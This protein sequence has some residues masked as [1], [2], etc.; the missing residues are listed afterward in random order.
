MGDSWFSPFII[1]LNFFFKVVILFFILS[2]IF[3]KL[4]DNNYISANHVLAIA[5]NISH[6]PLESIQS[7]C[8]HCQGHTDGHTAPVR[9]ISLLFFSNVSS[10]STL[11][12]HFSLQTHGYSLSDFNLPFCSSSLG[13][14]LSLHLCNHFKNTL[15]HSCVTELDYVVGV[16]IFLC[17]V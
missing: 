5:F 6:E 17:M 13:F 3:L 16:Y 8:L 2:W 10:A 11:S 1:Q 9:L 15:A 7:V 4:S 12:L 14:S